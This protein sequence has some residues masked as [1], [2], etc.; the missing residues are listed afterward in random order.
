[1]EQFFLKVANRKYIDI[2]HSFSGFPSNG[3]WIVSPNGYSLLS[4]NMDSENFYFYALKPRITE[5]IESLLQKGVIDSFYD[6]APYISSYLRNNI[7]DLN[8]DSV[9][10]NRHDDKA[11]DVYKKHNGR[12]KRLG[13]N[14]T[15]FIRTGYYLVYD[16]KENEVSFVEHIEKPDTLPDVSTDE[17]LPFISDKTKQQQHNL[18]ISMVE[19]AH[20]YIECLTYKIN[21]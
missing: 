8:I 5:Y 14:F 7:P 6:S 19:F 9:P 15:S 16:G 18:C 10:V 12:Y 1:M 11:Y 13:Q 20:Y 21:T 3:F 17:L 4:E 2:T